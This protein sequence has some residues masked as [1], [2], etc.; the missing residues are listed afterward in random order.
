MVRIVELFEAENLTPLKPGKA[1]H[2]SGI[3]PDV[4]TLKTLDKINTHHGNFK[5][6]SMDVGMPNKWIPGKG[7]VSKTP[8][9]REAEQRDLRLAKNEM[10]AQSLAFVK[11]VRQA[12]P[13]IQK[14]CSKYLPI[15][16]NVGF[17]YR[18]F[19]VND[20][21]HAVFYGRPRADRTPRDSD[22]EL[23]K[24]FDFALDMEG[25]L[26]KRRNSLFVAGQK[27]QAEGYGLPFIII[28]CNDVLYAWSR[29]VHDIVLDGHSNLEFA[30]LVEEYNKHHIDSE[31]FVRE[32]QRMFRIEQTD[33]EKAMASEHEIWIHGHYVAVLATLEPQLR[34]LLFG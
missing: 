28:P 4:K 14:N 11:D 13:F 8:D 15:M 10:N 29:T 34:K 18:G 25:I 19:N 12:V 6:T 31:D 1:S 2:I 16:H 5:S 30:K 21:P 23:Q 20:L 27:A 26:A 17:L 33:L 24:M 3:E 22:P 32:F 9:E 7:F